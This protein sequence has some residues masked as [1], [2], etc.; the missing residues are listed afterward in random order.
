MT[1][2]AIGLKNLCAA[3]HATEKNNNTTTTT[4]DVRQKEIQ[5][6]S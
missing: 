6:L 3:C 5:L 2:K 1:L 4:V